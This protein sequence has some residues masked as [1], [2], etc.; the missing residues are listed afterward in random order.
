MPNV[1]KND[2]FIIRYQSLQ[3]LVC[4][5]RN[6][7]ITNLVVLYTQKKIIEVKPYLGGVEKPCRIVQV[8]R[9]RYV[10]DKIAV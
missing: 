1:A 3:K 5:G 10:T 2:L 4:N 8:H 7:Y 6:C 9:N